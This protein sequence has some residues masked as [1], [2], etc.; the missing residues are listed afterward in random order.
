MNWNAVS[1]IG[2]T[3]AAIVG[4]A[5]IW[6]NIWDKTKKLHVN[7]KAVPHFKISLSNDSLRAVAIIKMVY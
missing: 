1:A 6:V 2:T 7:F 5:G 3:L 4:I